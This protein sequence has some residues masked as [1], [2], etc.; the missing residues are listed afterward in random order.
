MTNDTI[1]QLHDLS[2]TITEGN[3]ALKTAQTIAPLAPVNFALVPVRVTIDGV[4]YGG[5]TSVAVIAALTGKAASTVY[6][7]AQPQSRGY[8]TYMY[9]NMCIEFGVKVKPTAD[10]FVDAIPLIREAL[11]AA[12]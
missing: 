6:Q 4:E 7:Y 3:T 1:L 9:N 12:E 10:G 11:S 5:H 8:W 2:K